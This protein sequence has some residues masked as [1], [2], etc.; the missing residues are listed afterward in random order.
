[1]RSM[2][3]SVGDVVVF[4]DGS[5]VEVEVLKSGNP[6]GSAFLPAAGAIELARLV[7][8]AVSAA[9][10]PD[11]HAI[12]MLNQFP[13]GKVRVTF[14]TETP[15][16]DHNKDWSPAGWHR[17]EDVEVLESGDVLVTWVQV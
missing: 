3:G 15:V 1:M 16:I 11:P 5:E 4:R 13:S 10:G 2:I 17:C 6:I 14:A 8:R 7:G 12:R 9:G